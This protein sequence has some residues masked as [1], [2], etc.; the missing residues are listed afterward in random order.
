MNSPSL[1]ERARGLR[2]LI[3]AEADATEALGTM[4][5]AVVDAIEEA[6]LFR[7]LVPAELGGHEVDIDTLL[8]ISEELSYADGSV[9]WSFVQNTTLGGYLAYLDPELARPFA[10]RRAGAGMFA[11]LGVAREEPGGYRVSGKFQFGSGSG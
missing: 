10:K 1:L 11:P 9:G 4:S 7:I 6:G 8:A 5:P 2:D 3:Q